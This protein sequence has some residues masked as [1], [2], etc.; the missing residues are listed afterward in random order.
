[1]KKCTGKKQKAAS[2]EN[3]SEVTISYFRVAFT[4][5]PCLLLCNLPPPLKTILTWIFENGILVDDV[6]SQTGISKHITPQTCVSS[7][8]ELKLSL[9]IIKPSRKEAQEPSLNTLSSSASLGL[10]LT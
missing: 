5:N 4:C 7:T 2:T 10:L 9:H 3:Y 1:M 6:Q 8:A